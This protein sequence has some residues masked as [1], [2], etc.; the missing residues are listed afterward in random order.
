MLQYKK[1]NHYYSLDQKDFWKLQNIP[2]HL[3]NGAKT[4]KLKLFKK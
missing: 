3:E 1:N 2:L 4:I